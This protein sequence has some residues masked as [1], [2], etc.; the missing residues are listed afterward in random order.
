MLF[1]NILH[2]I[3]NNYKV[4]ENEI[5]NYLYK[6]INRYLLLIVLAY[7]FC[8][9]HITFYLG[10]TAISTNH[11]LM[12]LYFMIL[13]LVKKGKYIFNIDISIYKVI[14]YIVLLSSITFLS[15]YTNF[16]IKIDY[17]Y[18]PIIGAI[19]Y[20]FNIKKELGYI[21]FILGITVFLFSLPFL[22]DL[23]FIPKISFRLDQK[24]NVGTTTV[25]NASFSFIV[26]FI[27]MYF[28]Y[29]KDQHIFHLK[30]EK[31]K[32]KSYYYLLQ[33][34]YN[35]LINNQFIINNI[36]IENID[37]IYKLAE[38]NSPL[39]FEKFCFL[40][41]TFKKALEDIAPELTYND[42]FFCS[43]CKLNFGTK[44]LAQILDVSVRSI[45]SR[46][47][48]LNKKLNPNNEV[49]FQEF[50]IKIQ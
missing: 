33:E 47:Y 9:I 16:L 50:I 7:I 1:Q 4:T 3:L 40:F 38:T 23:T 15:I 35:D 10:Y 20:I 37:E 13:L 11:L 5:D 30:S 8:F 24:I 6:S 28:I 14:S 41:P 27:N 2:K 17:F 32:I 43:L 45:E 46:K 49:S 44:K 48:R 26:L 34:K 36:T 39:Y 31:E 29:K 22:F 25:L 42:L 19:P 18:F 12:I 21:Y